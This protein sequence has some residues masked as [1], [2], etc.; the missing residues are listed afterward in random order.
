MKKVVS[1]L[2]AALMLLTLFPTAVWAQED[3]A[4]GSKTEATVGEDNTVQ[5]A[6]EKEQGEEAMISNAPGIRST[7]TTGDVF[8]SGQCGENLTWTLEDGTLTI[9]GTGDMWDYAN[10]ETLSLPWASYRAQ[11]VALDL[12]NGITSLGSYCFSSL[13]ITTLTIPGSVKRIEDSAFQNNDKLVDLVIE[14]G[15]EH[16]GKWAFS[17]CER[18]TNVTIP[19]SVTKMDIFPFDGCDALTSIYFGGTM[20]AWKSISSSLTLPLITSVFCNDGTIEPPLSGSCG[21]NVSYNITS[22]GTLTISGTGDMADYTYDND[23]SDCPWHNVRFCIKNVVIEEGVT[24]IGSYA[25]GFNINMSDISIPNSV[26]TIGN[27]AFLGTNLTSISLPEGVTTIGAFAFQCCTNLRIIT[28][29][30]SV[31]KIGNSAFYTGEYYDNEY[32]HELTDVYYGGS[33]TEW[34]NAGGNSAGLYDTVNLHFGTIA[35]IAAGSCGDNATWTL[36]DDGTLTISG[37]GAMYDYEHIN[38]GQ[39][40]YVTNPWWKDYAFAIQKIVIGEGITYI[41]NNA[42]I[43]N[44][45]DSIS[46]PSTVR[47]IGEYSFAGSRKV[48]EINVPDGVETIDVAAFWACDEL[49]SITI[50]TSVQSMGVW[51]LGNCDKLKTITFKGTMEQWIDCGGGAASYTGNAV[52]NCLGGGILNMSGTCGDA[53]TWTLDSN[54][55]L[56]LKGS[57]AMYDYRYDARW[58]D[59]EEYAGTTTAPWGKAVSMIKNIVIDDGIT[60]IGEYAFMDTNNTSLTIPGSVEKIGGDAF[61]TNRY[62]TTLTLNQGLTAI[63]VAAFQGCNRLTSVAIPEGVT[64]VGAYAFCW[65]FIL[66][67]EGSVAIPGSVTKIG[68]DAFANCELLSSVTFSG[69]KEQ[70]TAIGGDNAG[71]PSTAVLTCTGVASASGK[72]GDNATYVLTDNG[73]LIISGIGDMYDYGDSD[74]NVEGENAPWRDFGTMMDSINSVV[75]GDG[76]TSIGN[77]AFKHCH[78][79]SAISLPDTVTCIGISAFENCTS[80]Q[81]VY[82]PYSVEIIRVCAFSGCTSMENA[83]ICADVIGNVAFCGCTSLKC[84]SISANVTSITYGAF[85]NCTALEYVNYSGTQ[86]GWNKISIAEKNEPLKNATIICDYET[87]GDVNA[88]GGEPDISDVASLYTY[89]TSSNIVGRHSE[90]AGYRQVADVNQDGNVDVYD[91][92]RLYE[93]VSSIRPF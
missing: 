6:K 27:G 77:R 60:Y 10:D 43:F 16:I 19:A 75:V 85:Q 57:G 56:T 69:S 14:P 36:T 34:A 17:D 74:S 11:I 68:E 42:F 93:A 1:F 86:Q 67:D 47:G 59:S 83:I 37:T 45:A 13:N 20:N 54:G 30:A 35:T 49:T 38:N 9:S 81:K 26:K 92:Q 33:A 64:E 84:V 55:S 87:L 61:S 82:I 40:E 29:P 2:L 72:C 88:S 8:A 5:S 41:G 65:C 3:A 89:L 90:E 63:D 79:L 71:L 12:E 15:V 78:N 23:S 73:T 76:I 44:I 32:H 7:N 50:P 53:I 28:I 51:T 66:V 48:K 18:L 21:A 91:L 22:D 58:S 24:H 4:L 70:W 46:I 52:V 39:E 25:F 31:T 80:L 62:L